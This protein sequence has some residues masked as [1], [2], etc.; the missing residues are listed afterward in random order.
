MANSEAG[1]RKGLL[2]RISSV[3]SLQREEFQA[4]INA[5]NLFFGAIIGVN[6]S[7]LQELPPKDYAIVLFL[8]ASLIALILIVSNTRRGVWSAFQ[9]VV[10]LAGYFYLFRVDPLIEG[11]SDNLMVTLGVW[12]ACALLYE[13]GTPV[14]KDEP[15]D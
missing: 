11:I 8:T 5:L 3:G 15:G 2:R 6:F 10:A 4:S 7:D 13:F 1:K 14:E 12:A 9:L